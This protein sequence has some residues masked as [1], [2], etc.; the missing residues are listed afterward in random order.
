MGLV[1]FAETHFEHAMKVANLA[2]GMVRWRKL[3]LPS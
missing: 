2:G 3:G 1:D